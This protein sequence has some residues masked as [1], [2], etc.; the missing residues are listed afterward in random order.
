[1]GGGDEF[2]LSPVVGALEAAVH[3]VHQRGQQLGC[4]ILRVDQGEPC[5]GR[6][7]D[8]RAADDEGSAGA[9]EHRS[10]EDLVQHVAGTAIRI[11]EF[12]RTTKPRSTDEGV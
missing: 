2:D 5:R 10:A 3:L 1:M 6:Q 9:H 4:F 7:A 8:Y 11:E 12:Q